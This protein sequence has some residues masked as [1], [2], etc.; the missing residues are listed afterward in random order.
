MSTS[1]INISKSRSWIGL[2][3][4]RG[5]QGSSLTWT[6]IPRQPVH[7]SHPDMVKKPLSFQK[8]TKVHTLSFERRTRNGWLLAL[9]VWSSSVYFTCT[10]RTTYRFKMRRGLLHQRR[11]QEFRDT[12]NTS[13]RMKQ[14]SQ[15]IHEP[16][17]KKPMI[18]MKL[19]WPQSV[20]SIFTHDRW[21]V[22]KR[23]IE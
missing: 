21:P 4:F 17:Y 23:M 15:T 18:D 19:P 8:P 7:H 14:C 20:A 2:A 13:E 1:C 12:M 22:P 3:H 16:C 6:L 10:S 9:P 11:L 5:I